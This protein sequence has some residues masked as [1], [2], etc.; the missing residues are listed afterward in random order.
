MICSFRGQQTDHI[1]EI[2]KFDEDYIFNC[3]NM[4]LKDGIEKAKKKYNE[5]LK[6]SF[7]SIFLMI[8]ILVYR[9]KFKQIDKVCRNF[10]E[11]NR[12]LF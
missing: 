6:P 7:K 8:A 2:T 1:I 5:R 3:V 11:R 10:Y 9:K 12:K 4:T